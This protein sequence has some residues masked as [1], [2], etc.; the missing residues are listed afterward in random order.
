MSKFA[1]EKTVYLL[2]RQRE[3]EHRGLVE[4]L[5]FFNAR[6]NTVSWVDVKESATKFDELDKIESLKSLQESFNSFA[7]TNFEY[8]IL[9]QTEDVSAL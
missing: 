3:V 5:A 2:Q 6:N 9:K 4:E 7:E 1:G 8:F